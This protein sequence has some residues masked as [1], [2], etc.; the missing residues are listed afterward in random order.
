MQ[1][2]CWKLGHRLE[3]SVR[4][5]ACRRCEEWWSGKCCSCLWVGV[6]SVKV[7]LLLE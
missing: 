2:R 7:S 3:S 4:G 5:V 6:Q 1:E